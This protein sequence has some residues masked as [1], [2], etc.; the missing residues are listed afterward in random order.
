MPKMSVIQEEVITF[1]AARMDYPPQTPAEREA[2]E[3]ALHEACEDMPEADF[4]TA[5]KQYRRT[6]KKWPSPAAIV[7]LAPAT[8]GAAGAARIAEAERAVDWWPLVQRSIGSAGKD[9][10]PARLR[11]YVEAAAGRSGLTVT[12][13][14]WEAI[15]RGVDACGGIRAIGLAPVESGWLAVAFK[16]AAQAQTEGGAL[17]HLEEE[18]RKRIPG[19][20]AWRRIGG[21]K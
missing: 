21:G 15:M 10:D 5:C 20:A 14:A 9:S 19:S 3:R 6:G 8:I 13:D 16:R 7:E 11:R 2:Y 12:D 4:R 18:R 1:L 17:L